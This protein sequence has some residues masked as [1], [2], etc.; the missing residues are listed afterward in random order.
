MPRSQP[1]TSLT[2]P[3]AQYQPIIVMKH[4]T[5]VLTAH[6]SHRAHDAEAAVTQLGPL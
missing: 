2:Q 4:Y 3:T 6:R 5:S 1:N